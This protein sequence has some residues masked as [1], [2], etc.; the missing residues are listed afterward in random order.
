[1]SDRIIRIGM[2]SFAH[3]HAVSYLRELLKTEGVQVAGIYDP[4]Y[5]R[6]SAHVEQFGIPYYDDHMSLLAESIDAVVICSENAWHGRFTADAARAGKHVLCEKP[7]GVSIEQMQEMIDVCRASGVQLMTAF[8]CRYLASVIDA[9]AAVARG[10]IGEILAIK[11]TNRGRMPGRWFVEPAL[12]G[13]GAVLD[14]TVH[15]MDLMNWFLGA[16][17]VE[18]YA[19]VDTLFN[20]G[21]G[22]D[23]AGMVHVKFSNGAIGIL[24]P[25]WSRPN[26]YN[27]PGDVAMEIIG[28]HGVIS[29]D[30]FAQA[31]EAYSI[32]TGKTTRSFWGDGM[33]GPLVRDFV[34]ALRDGANVPI[35]GEDGLR[36]A[37][38]AVAA[39]ESAKAGAPVKVRG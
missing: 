31:N 22:I 21:L 30:G 28:T 6:V 37:A 14:H 36:S 8:P 3:S 33:D 17:P 32:A 35:S 26:D 38:V 24:D 9:K 39:Y 4:D 10:E 13:G 18:V 1:M 27:R 16:V 7:L 11:G 25:S 19:E 29:V 15:V 5:S 34:R 20:E 12:S 23:D 2:I